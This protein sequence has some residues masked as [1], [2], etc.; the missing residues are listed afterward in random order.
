MSHFR[1]VRTTTTRIIQVWLIYSICVEHLAIRRH[2]RHCHRHRYAVTQCTSHSLIKTFS[3]NVI[4]CRDRCYCHSPHPN[5]ECT[6]NR[7]YLLKWHVII[8]HLHAPNLSISFPFSIPFLHF[9]YIFPCLER[10]LN[11]KNTQFRQLPTS[12]V[13]SISYVFLCTTNVRNVSIWI[14]LSWDKRRLNL[15]DGSK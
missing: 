11:T 3:D 1:L 12:N 2:H 4:W 7:K 6:S 15:K 8:Q 13:S 9:A 5:S 14:V 10:A